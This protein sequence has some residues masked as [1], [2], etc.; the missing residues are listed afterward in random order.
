[1]PPTPSRSPSPTPITARRAR[2]WA[3]RPP[4]LLRISQ[5][6]TLVIPGGRQADLGSTVPR[7][8]LWIPAL[9]C[10]PAGMTA[11]WRFDRQAARRDRQLRRGLRHRRRGGR[12]LPRALLVAHAPAPALGRRGGDAVD[13]DPCPRGHDPAFRLP[14]GP[15]AGVV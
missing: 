8:A 10:A 7:S 6:A 5:P 14:L 2:L 11:R 13:R 9:R 1:M 15:G 12:R 3:E 4:T